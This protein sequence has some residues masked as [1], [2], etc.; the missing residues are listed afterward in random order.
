MGQEIPTLT[1]KEDMKEK[2]KIR[3]RFLQYYMRV[4]DAESRQQIGNLVDITPQGIMIVS[5][6][7][8]PKDQTSRIRLE[9]SEEVSLKPYIEF[10]AISRWSEQDVIPNMY[11]TGFEI[12]E[13]TP[14]DSAVINQIVEEFG[15]RDDQPGN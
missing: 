12:L 14:E 13:L 6:H 15:F 3:R 10:T 4:Y 7:I 1:G 5:E 11:N 2:R 9:L 8:L